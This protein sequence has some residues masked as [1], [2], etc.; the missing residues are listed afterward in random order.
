MDQ[1]QT[2][3][4][5][6]RFESLLYVPAFTQKN[7]Y[8]VHTGPPTQGTSM[9]EFTITKLGVHNSS[10]KY[11]HLYTLGQCKKPNHNH[12]YTRGIR[13]KAKTQPQSPLHKRDR[14]KAKPQSPLHKRNKA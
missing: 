1:T 2:P 12:L 4:Y 13:H 14:H 10:L 9:E 7:F 5:V 8:Y 3:R 6:L 11:N